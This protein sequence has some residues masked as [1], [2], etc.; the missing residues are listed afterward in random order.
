MS[1]GVIYWRWRVNPQGHSKGKAVGRIPPK[2]GEAMSICDIIMVL[3][4]DV[5]SDMQ[6]ATYWIYCILD[7]IFARK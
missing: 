1:Y 3:M 4:F 6:A 2:G 7:V 5:A